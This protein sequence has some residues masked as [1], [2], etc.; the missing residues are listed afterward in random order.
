MPVFL[1]KRG[2]FMKKII[3]LVAAVVLLCSASTVGAFAA[4]PKN[5]ADVTV[6]FSNAG[7]LELAQKPVRVTDTD[8]DGKLTI[9]DALYAMHEAYYKGGAAA[10]FA[11]TVHEQY[12]L[13]VTKL[14]GDDSGNFGYYLNNKTPMNAAEPVTDGDSITAFI[15]KD[16]EEFSDVYS[17][18][19]ANTYN[20]NLDK[21]NEFELQLKCIHFDYST[22][23]PTVTEE[24]LPDAD[25]TINGEKSAYK[26]D[27]DG[28]VK[29]K[30]TEQGS[31]VISAT[32]KELTLV[33]P[34]CV[35]TA[36]MLENMPILVNDENTGNQT[37]T[38]VK[39]SP[40]TG[41]AGETVVC[42]AAATLSLGA[43][44]VLLKGK[45][46]FNED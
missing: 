7:E 35:V 10:G 9:A 27:A 8:K 40:K 12:G 39:K 16:I 28:K 18:F 30:L 45:N 25:I 13:Y 22:D 14:W 23:I 1:K 41:Y 33:P 2:N 26:T 19:N 34:V 3:S 15:Y 31:Y 37:K 38:E 43:M 44:A 36:S 42:L 20:L 6:N 17:Y 11:T 24:V 46:K 32:S 5:S 29:I 21:T 4:E